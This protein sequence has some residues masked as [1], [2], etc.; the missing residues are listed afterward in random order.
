M[1]ICNKN[2]TQTSVSNDCIYIFLLYSTQFGDVLLKPRC[3]QVAEFY[4]HQNTSC[5]VTGVFVLNRHQHDRTSR[6]HLNDQDS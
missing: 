6:Y 3:L 5:V 2:E 1:N 4:K